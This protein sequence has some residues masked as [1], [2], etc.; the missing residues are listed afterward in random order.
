MNKK[1]KEFINCKKLSEKICKKMNLFL[2][3]LKEIDFNKKIIVLSNVFT[4]LTINYK[5]MEIINKKNYFQ[6]EL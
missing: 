2:Y 1:T 5:S 3:D 6:E 4:D